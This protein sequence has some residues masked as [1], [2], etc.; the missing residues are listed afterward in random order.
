M[1]T[2][3]TGAEHDPPPPT[4]DRQITRQSTQLD[5]VR[6]EIDTTTH[7]IDHA[8]GLLVNLLLHEMGELALHDL[9]QLEL[10]GL[11]G[12]DGAGSRTSGAGRIGVRATETVDVQLALADVRDVVV[13]EVQDALGVLDDGGRVGRDEEFD[14]LRQT[15][16][17]HE[18]S[19]LCARDLA[20]GTAAGTSGN[21]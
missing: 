9:R 21:G 10:E 15:V 18:R 5:L 1:I 7:R 12:T 2:R 13:L 19:G 6:I 8:L 14:G 3:P 11:D 16:F 17:G 20:A 4:D